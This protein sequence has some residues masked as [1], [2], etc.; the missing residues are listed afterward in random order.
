MDTQRYKVVVNHG[1]GGSTYS[2][3]DT[4][5]PE[6]E[7]PAIVHSWSTAQEPNAKFLAEDFTQRHNSK[8]F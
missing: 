3:V 8:G 5:Q 1:E 2:V 7:Q 6:N 4:A